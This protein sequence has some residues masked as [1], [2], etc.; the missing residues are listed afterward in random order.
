MFNFHLDTVAGLL[1]VLIV[2]GVISHNNAITISACVLLIM[3]QTVLSAFLPAVMRHGL[4][5][6]IIILTIGVLSPLVAGKIQLPALKEL[7]IN[8]H[9]WAAIVVGIF[10][11]WLGGRG[12]SLMALQPALVTGLMIGTVIGVTFFK[13]IPVGP[14]IA[15]GILALIL[16]VAK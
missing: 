7:L 8:W 3:Q 9:L 12:V 11:A 6:G 5:I 4:S 13:G 1:L 14:L 16:D 2:L 10:V 15:A